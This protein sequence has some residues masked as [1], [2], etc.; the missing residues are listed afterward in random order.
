MACPNCFNMYD[1]KQLAFSKIYT[2][3]LKIKL[4]KTF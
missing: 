2:N 3:R 4:P 1:L